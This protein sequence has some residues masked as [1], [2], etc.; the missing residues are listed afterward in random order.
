MNNKTATVAIV[1]LLSLAGNGVSAQAATNEPQKPTATAEQPKL[2]PPAAPTAVG[3]KPPMGDTEKAPPEHAKKE[4]LFL[5]GRIQMR[6][7]TGQRDTFWS[8]GHS[9][10]NIADFNFS[11]LRLGAIYQLDK[12]WSMVVDMRLE[13]ALNRPYVTTKTGN[14]GGTTCV[15]SV[16]LN[17]NRGLLQEASIS[18]KHEF[19]GLAV[20]LG[21]VRMPFN[22]EYF[23]TS[24]NLINIERAMATGGV[25]QWD[26]GLRLDL[27]P[28]SEILGEKYKYYLGI[29]GMVST[30]HG[31][32]GDAGFGRR[33]DMQQ[34][35]GA[36]SV[37]VSPMFSGRVEYNIFGGLSKDGK[38][39][40][41]REGDEIFQRD[42]KVSLGAGFLGINETK[43]GE[44]MS[45]EYT[46]R[47][48]SIQLTSASGSGACAALPSG[49]SC[50]LFAQ[51]YDFTATYAGF[52]GNGSYQYYGGPAG[53]NLSGY[54][55]T[56]GYNIPAYSNAFVMPVV[57]Y[58]FMKGNL[59]APRSSGLSSDPANQFSVVWVGVNLFHSHHNLKLQ[60]FYNIMANN[61]KGYDA[62]GNA[63]GGYAQNLLIFQAQ[64]NFKTGTG[65]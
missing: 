3:T 5:T 40:A 32:A 57:R 21:L 44:K 14:C 49:T 16:S 62:A 10:Y 19:L 51:T 2:T 36:S 58:D 17:E 47:S 37:P 13:N 50:S 59:A 30:G 39:T 4:K 34:T 60:L 54:T 41:W 46:P 63:A 1:C 45:T 42:L 18:Y 61:Y 65:I 7:M 27:Y 22:R 31:G 53:Q 12:H 9:D 35:Q 43:G 28:L 15:T 38:D 55:F 26:N 6:T 24:A 52:Y 20:S 23:T 29:Y 48:T 64:M 8:T 25:H 11:R 56:L 33:Y